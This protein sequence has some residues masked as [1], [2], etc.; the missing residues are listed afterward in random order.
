MV[1]ERRK[2]PEKPSVMLINS[3]CTGFIDIPDQ[4]SLNLYAQGCKKR[5]RGC[6]NPDLQS[7]DGGKELYISDVDK[8]LSEFSLCTWICWLGGDAVYQEDALIQFNQEFKQ[9]GLDICIYTGL[10]FGELSQE[11]LGSLDLVIDG[12]WNGIPVT[13]PGSNQTIYSKCNDEW[14]II[15]NWDCLELIKKECIVRVD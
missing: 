7:F 15:S 8:L 6:H 1:G 5:C 4:I 14:S 13:E 12:E 3:I 2:M 10:K 11:L 9:R